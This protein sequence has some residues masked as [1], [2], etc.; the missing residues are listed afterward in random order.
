[1]SPEQEVAVQWT[2]VPGSKLNV[3]TATLTMLREIILIPFCYT[4]GIWSVQDG[5]F[6]LAPRVA[7]K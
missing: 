2:E 4:V 5:R 1:V 6:R 3:I 7:T